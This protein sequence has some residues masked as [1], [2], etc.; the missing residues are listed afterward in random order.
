MNRLDQ[1]EQRRHRPGDVI[2]V[3]NILILFRLLRWHIQ[4]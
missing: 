1:P 4:H 3:Y 2:D